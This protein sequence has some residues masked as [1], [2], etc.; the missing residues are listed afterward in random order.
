MYNNIN[1]FSS[2]ETIKQMQR[3]IDYYDIDMKLMK[4]SYTLRN[5]MKDGMFTEYFLNGQ[6]SLIKEYK[7]NTPVGKMIEYYENG[8]LKTSID[9]N[10]N[11]EQHGKQVI[12]YSN[13]NI[14]KIIEYSNGLPHGKWFSYYDD[15]SDNCLKVRSIDHFVYG[16]SINKSMTYYENGVLK[17]MTTF[18][19]DGKRN[20]VFKK[21]F[22]N[23]QL[24]C[25]KYYLD[26]K[27]NGETIEYYRSGNKKGYCII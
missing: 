19:A 14:F 18:S 10:F 8:R 22:D 24:K 16:K 6:I 7:R 26:D 21:F 2:N 15:S 4:R 1:L 5:G 17:S 12:Y 13:G 9:Y 3:I 27:L 11:G 23:Q 20:G 25:S